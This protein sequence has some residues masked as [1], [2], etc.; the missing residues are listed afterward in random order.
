MRSSPYIDYVCNLL[1]TR[2]SDAYYRL[3]ISHSSSE[4]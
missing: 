4:T 1:V 2:D 3:H